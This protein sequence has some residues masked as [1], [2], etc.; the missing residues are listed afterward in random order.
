M[1]R[2]IDVYTPKL[3]SE[4]KQY[5]REKAVA[6]LF[7]GITVGIVALPLAM[8][9]AIAS[10]LPPERG[11]FTAIVAGFLIS[12]LG[13]SSVQIGG[14][15]GA[16]VVLV[17]AVAT[18][19]GYSGLALCTLIAGVFLILFGVFRMGG[20]I[21]FIPFPVTT[22][23]TTGIAVVIFSTQIRDLLGL[24]VENVPAEFLLKWQVYLKNLGSFDPQT[25]AI[26]FGTI[27]VIVMVRRF[28]P[29]LPAMLIGMIAATVLAAALHLDVAT[30]GSRFGDLPRM[31]PAPSLPKFDLAQIGLLVKPAFTIA[32]LAAIESL[33]SATVADGM[34]GGRHKPNA[35]LI[36]QGVANIGSVLFGGIPATGAIARTATNVKSG[37]KTPV[38]GIIHSIVL[39]LLLLLCAP[40]AKLIPLS[41]LAGILVVVSYNMSELHHFVSIFKGPKSDAFVLV[42]TF[43]LTVLVDLTVAVQVGVV[44]ASLL[45]IWRMSEITDVSMITKEVRGEEDFGDD[46]N[47]IALR[48]VPVGV[49]VFEVNGPF[50]FGMV[51]EF[52]NALRNLEKPVP[53]LI[54][55]T[56]KVSAIDATAIHVLRELYHRCQK[57]KTQLIFSGVQPQPRRAFRRSGFIE[58]VGAENFCKDI[59]EALMRARAVLG[60]AKGD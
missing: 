45:F 22:G 52:K 3:L 10:G 44:M 33:L 36:A 39:A 56:R 17:S 41:A 5:S 57:E 59:D 19:Y 21:K 20:F 25:V 14:P 30:I 48:K 18:E 43:A 26:G 8:A 49:E 37:A 38:A 32:L 58:E 1:K 34:I 28:W 51:N 29:K 24:N 12:A 16:F 46:P 11:L 42:L 23:F 35:E 55:R 54:I 4:L 9:F 2:K 27:L 13:G 47:A 60:L 53:V 7:A 31:L 15:T 40:I 50:F 6:D